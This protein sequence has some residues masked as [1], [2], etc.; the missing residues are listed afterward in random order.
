MSTIP[1][2]AKELLTIHEVMAYA[3]VSRRTVYNW[4]RAGKLTWVETPSGNRRILAES[5]FRQPAAAA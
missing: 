5:I 2:E 4:M 1:L 3:K